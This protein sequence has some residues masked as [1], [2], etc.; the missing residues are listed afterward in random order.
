MTGSDPSNWTASSLATNLRE[1]HLEDSPSTPYAIPEFQGGA[2]DSW[3]SGIG[4]EGCAALINNE[5]ERVFYKNNFA[6][7][8]AIF[9]LYM[10]RR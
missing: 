9:N 3:G 8:I 6:A 10:V 1:L 7:G 2:I 4:L 5:F